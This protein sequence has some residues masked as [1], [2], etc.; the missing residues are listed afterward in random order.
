MDSKLKLFIVAVRLAKSLDDC[1]PDVGWGPSIDLL[2]KDVERQ[3][4]MTL[5]DEER[6]EV[7]EDFNNRRR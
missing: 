4:G 5:T 1:D 7:L 3:A 2:I 6:A